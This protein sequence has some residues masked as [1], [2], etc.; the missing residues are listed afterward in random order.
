MAK[1]NTFVKLKTRRSLSMIT[2]V[3]QYTERNMSIVGNTGRRRDL[4]DGAGKLSELDIKYARD[5]F[6]LVGH[7]IIFYTK[8][9]CIAILT[10]YKNDKKIYYTHLL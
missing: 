6:V 4:I 3:I 9:E 8:R 2:T 7:E 1:N 5:F 10:M